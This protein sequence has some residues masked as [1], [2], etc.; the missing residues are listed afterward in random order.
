MARTIPQW[1][2]RDMERVRPAKVKHGLE[3][4]AECL[5]H[6]RRFG[7]LSSP[8]LKRK[9]YN[10]GNDER[11]NDMRQIAA[12]LFIS[13]D[14]VVE[15]PERWG[16]QYMDNDMSEGIVAGIARADAV[17]LGP[18]TYRR[19]ARLAAPNG[20]WANAQGPEPL[21]K[22]VGVTNRAQARIDRL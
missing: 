19:F 3:V 13:L 6:L 4:A 18:A 1:P 2:G 12:G 9:R 17:L 8:Q 20:R 16:F 11:R 7:K 21:H 14:G 22:Q 15:F 10:R 5:G